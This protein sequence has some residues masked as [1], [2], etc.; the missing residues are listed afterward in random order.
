MKVCFPF[1]ASERIAV[2][3]ST[4]VFFCQALQEN[5]FVEE[6]YFV[7]NSLSFNSCDLLKVLTP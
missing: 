2:T 4:C 7:R 5:H 6:K 3:S 1:S